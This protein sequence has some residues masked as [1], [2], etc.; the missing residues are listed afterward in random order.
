MLVYA[1]VGS[2]VRNAT[3]HWSELMCNHDIIILLIDPTIRECRSKGIGD[4][5]SDVTGLFTVVMVFGLYI[6]VDLVNC[7]G[8]YMAPWC[9]VGRISVSFAS[10]QVTRGGPS[11]PPLLVA[12]SDFL[13][14]QDRAHGVE[15]LMEKTTAQT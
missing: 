11:G 1:L 6:A 3:C 4:F 5:I 2:L 12:C 8:C 14:G 15:L 9:E 10:E 13:F 7:S